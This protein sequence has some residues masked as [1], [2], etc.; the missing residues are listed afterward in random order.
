MVT[1]FEYIQHVKSR[2]R[3]AR[4]V[5]GM[6]NM[7]I[8]RKTDLTYPTVCSAFREGSRQHIDLVTIKEI[9]DAMRVSVASIFN[10]PAMNEPLQIITKEREETE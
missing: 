10:C 9:C 1:E 3:K 5:A 7:A 6:T 4:K 8:C 2:L